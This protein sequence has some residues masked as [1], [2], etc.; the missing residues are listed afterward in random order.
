MSKPT[1]GRSVPPR[2]PGEVV[3][4]AATVNARKSVKIRES[5]TISRP[6]AE[7]YAIWRDFARLPSY[8]EDLEIVTVSGNRSH[9][10]MKLPVGTHSEW[11]AEIV[12]DVPGEIVAWKTVGASDLAH[13]GS[14]NLRDVPGGTEM[15]VE[16]DYEPPGGKLSELVTRFAGLFGQSPDA[17]VRADLEHFK[18]RVEEESPEAVKD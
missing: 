1:D 8:I 9:W 12:N 11:D 7:V 6:R 16:I 14:I 3:S 15:R 17:K 18:E 5:I 13:A 2:A 10:R 4:D